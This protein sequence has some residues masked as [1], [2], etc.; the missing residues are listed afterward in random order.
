MPETFSHARKM[1]TTK[2]KSAKYFAPQIIP[3]AHTAI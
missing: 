2:R 1:R 3:A